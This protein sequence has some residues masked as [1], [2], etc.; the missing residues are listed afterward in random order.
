MR[1]KKLERQW[2]EAKVELVNGVNAYINQIFPIYREIFAPYVGKKIYIGSG[3]FVAPLR[4]KIAEIKHDKFHVYQYSSMYS[5]CY[6]VKNHVC[7]PSK[8]KQREDDRITMYYEQSF[9]VADLEYDKLTLKKLYEEDKS[10]KT[11]YKA[12]DIQAARERF[13]KAKKELDEARS[14]LYPFGES[15]K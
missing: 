11:D 6:V 15:E 10:F 3:E 13:Q 1:D 5:I 4:K 7:V 14:A 2:L 12:D 9:Y 8:I